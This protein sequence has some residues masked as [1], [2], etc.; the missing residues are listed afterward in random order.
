MWRE[1]STDLQVIEEFIENLRNFQSLKETRFEK[2][3]DAVQMSIT[4]GTPGEDWIIPPDEHITEEILFQDP[5][6]VRLRK[7]LT[8]A[9]APLK[10]IATFLHFDEHHDFD[11]ITFINPLI[12]NAALDDGLR[13]SKALLKA[14]E[15]KNYPFQNLVNLVRL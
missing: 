11:W 5:D 6:Y 12:G 14:C 15:D 1:K 4:P 13:I 7:K 2:I 3:D 8:D 10:N 9:I